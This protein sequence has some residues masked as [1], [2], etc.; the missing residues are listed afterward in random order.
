MT[1]LL[2]LSIHCHF[3]VQYIFIDASGKIC[4]LSTGTYAKMEKSNYLCCDPIINQECPLIFVHK[5]VFLHFWYQND[6]VI[7]W[8]F[9]W[10]LIIYGFTQQRLEE[11]CLQFIILYIKQFLVSRCILI[12]T[13]NLKT[14]LTDSVFLFYNQTFR[15][16]LFTSNINNLTRQDGEK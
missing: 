3:F 8:I 14:S 5:L 16:F 11:N 2:P 1:I 10:Y 15:I 13:Q 6:N 12:S 9:L 7:W 4:E